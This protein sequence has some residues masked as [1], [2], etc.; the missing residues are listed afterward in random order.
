[1]L[2]FC[3]KIQG[4]FKEYS[5]IKKWVFK[6]SSKQVYSVLHYVSKCFH[7]SMAAFKSSHR[8]KM[9]FKRQPQIELL[10]W[11]IYYHICNSSEK[12][13]KKKRKRGPEE[14]QTHEVDAKSV[15]D[16]VICAQSLNNFNAFLHYFPSERTFKEFLLFAGTFSKYS[17]FP[18]L[19]KRPWNITLNS[20]AF[21]ELHGIARTLSSSNLVPPY[22]SGYVRL[23]TT[24]TTTS[25]I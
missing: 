16:F 1:M 7:W 10:N 21:Q 4:V 14:N 9:H 5:S 22:G 25:F 17:S 11:L 20:R 12:F 23:I 19:F 13:H 2:V 6:G 15:P 24:T 18:G 3:H 8:Y